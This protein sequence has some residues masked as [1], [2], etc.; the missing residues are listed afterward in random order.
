MLKSLFAGVLALAATAAS[1][2]PI[3]GTGNPSSAVSGTLID[4]E[5]VALGSYATLTTQGLTI[6]GNGTFQIE[7]THAGGFN[8]TGARY[9][10]N[11]A[12]GTTVLTFTFSAPTSAFAFNLGA[13][14][15][16]SALS[17]F[18]GATMLE[19]LS[20]APTFGGNAGNY[21][22][23]SGAGIT[24]AT[25]TL[26]SRDYILLDRFA[27][28]A[29]QAEV[30]EPAMVGLLGLGILGIVAGRRRKIA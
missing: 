23:I 14:D 4:F 22:G 11:N 29:G 17:A 10:A 21:Y 13:Q 18:S 27:F 16:V 6:T 2:A 25:L 1:A 26:A 7:S 8:A 15:G 19:T 12:G 24:S 3:T 28:T 20:I 9:L 5:S 30:P